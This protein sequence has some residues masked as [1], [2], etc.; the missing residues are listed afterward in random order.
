MHNDANQC[1]FCLGENANLRNPF[2]TPCLCKGSIKFVHLRCLNT[3]RNNNT[4]KNYTLCTLCHSVYT[5][6]T[7]YA[8]EDIPHVKYFFIVL[9]HPILTNIALHYVWMLYAVS[10]FAD[11]IDILTSYRNYQI[12]YHIYYL[13]SVVRHFHVNKQERYFNAWRKEY[14]MVFFPL[15]GYIVILSAGSIFSFTWILSSIVITM[16]WNIHCHIL[17]EMNKEDIESIEDDE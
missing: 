6:P 1:R 9:N 2:L 8:I 4:E 17:A 10:I 16:F 3:W 7:E 11:N 14:R 13:S 15:Y 12:L 5:I